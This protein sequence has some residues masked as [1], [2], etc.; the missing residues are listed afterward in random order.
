MQKM[1]VAMV[2]AGVRSPFAHCF[3]LRL[4]RQVRC[5]VARRVA[6]AAVCCALCVELHCVVHSVR[7]QALDDD[8]NSPEARALSDFVEASMRNKNELVSYEAARVVCSLRRVTSREL[9]SAVSM[10]QMCAQCV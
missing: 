10:L 9:S 6:S 4:A 5:C 8:P 7:R 2:R 1:V 3:L